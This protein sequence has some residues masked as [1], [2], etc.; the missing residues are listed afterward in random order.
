MLSRCRDFVKKV[1]FGGYNDEYEDED[2]DED[3]DVWTLSCTLGV[4]DALS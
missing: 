2:E 3:E 1:H 4:T